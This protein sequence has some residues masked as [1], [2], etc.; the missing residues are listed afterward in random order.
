MF[1]GLVEADGRKTEGIWKAAVGQAGC[2]VTWDLSKLE[3]TSHRVRAQMAIYLLLWT[4]N[5]SVS[6]AL[7]RL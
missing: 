6:T 5:L 4:G 7:P 2:S 3:V 1:Q